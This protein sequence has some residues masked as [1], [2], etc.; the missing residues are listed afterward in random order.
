MFG[1]K[2]KPAAPKLLWTVQV[3]APGVWVTG[4]FDSASDPYA[5]SSFFEADTRSPNANITYLTLTSARVQPLDASSA[6]PGPG[7]P[8]P[9]WTMSTIGGFVAVLPGDEA[10]A[11]Y[12]VKKNTG[13]HAVQGDVFVG[14]FI[15]H[16]TI[17]YSGSNVSFLTSDRMFAILDA[18]IESPR[19]AG[20]FAGLKAACAVISTR[21]LQGM[22]LRE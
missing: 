18:E 15:I 5:L 1:S 19:F 16:G 3:L 21:L 9:R 4:S 10:S 2:D 8:L 7:G 6:S 14:S 11:A 13:K 17:Q 12:M 20:Q 22:A